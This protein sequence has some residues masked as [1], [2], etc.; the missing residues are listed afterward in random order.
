MQAETL[1]RDGSAVGPIVIA[2]AIE[3]AALEAFRTG[4]DGAAEVVVLP[5]PPDPKRATLLRSAV[6]VMT[7]NTAKDFSKEE[8]G[9]LDNAR[10]LQSF[11][12]GVDFMPLDIVP[13]HVPFACN[14]GAFAQPMAEHAVAMSLAAL[15]RL[16][17]EH[18]AVKNGVFNQYTRN[19]SLAGATVGI[20]GFGG[21][22]IATARLMRALG[23][24][25]IAINRRGQTSEALDFIGSMTDLD[26]LLA[27]SDVLLVSAPYTQETA[28]SIGARELQ[29][30][31]P[32]A[33]LVNLARGELIDEAALYAHLCANPAFTACIDAWW[34]EPVR[35]GEFRMDYPF[36]ALPNVIASPHN[37]ASVVRPG[38]PP[39][40]LAGE[41]CRRVVLGEAPLHVVD[42]ALSPFLS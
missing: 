9:L 21:I 6:A 12:A 13:E 33:V 41:N 23:A 28:N 29:L 19:R 16:L 18:D 20:Y 10:L 40:R 17:I 37:S 15:K 27:Q 4:V 26:W 2:Y 42:R 5:A 30:M 25:V 7:R 39:H 24:R 38:S 11:S 3:D 36:M 14:A 8:L 1:S 32:D 22:G 31:K 34:I 35:H